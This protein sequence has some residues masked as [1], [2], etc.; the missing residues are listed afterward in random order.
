MLALHHMATTLMISTLRWDSEVWWTDASHLIDSL[1]PTYLKIA[2]LITDLPSW[3]RSDKLLAA[4]TLLPSPGIPRLDRKEIRPPSHEEPRQPS[5]PNNTAKVQ[6]HRKRSRPRKNPSPIGQDYTSQITHRIRQKPNL[7]P[8]AVRTHNNRFQ[9]QPS[10]TARKLDNKRREC[11]NPLHRR[12]KKR[13]KLRRMVH[14]DQTKRNPNNTNE[15]LQPR[16]RCGH[17]RRRYPRHQ[18]RHRMNLEPN[19]KTNVNCLMC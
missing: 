6:T 15:M 13:T 10:Q 12:I 16:P 19:G 1:N 11:D 14:H 2:R 8:P 17:T 18:R 7:V 5:Q 3:T 4:S 9:G